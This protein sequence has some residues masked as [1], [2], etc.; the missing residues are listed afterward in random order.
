MR[1]LKRVEL[2]GFELEPGE[3]GLIRCEIV[4]G[5]L[6]ASD[7]ALHI[8]IC[9]PQSRRR[10]EWWQVKRASFDPERATLEIGLEN[11]QL[12]F[13]LTGSS[14]LPETVRE[15]VTATILTSINFAPGNHNDEVRAV[16]SLRRRPTK[17]GE[18]TFTEIDWQGSP[19]ESL[20][21]Q[22]ELRSQWLRQQAHG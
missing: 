10:I 8:S 17:D 13:G 15:R 18:V 5:H 4:G 2:V 12:D 21:A 19:S 20:R 3:R 7:A 16:I 14:L 9:Q 11:D 22:A 6:L 1:F